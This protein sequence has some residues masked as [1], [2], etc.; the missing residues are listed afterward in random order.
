MAQRKVKIVGKLSFV[1]D[2]S[3][4]VGRNNRSSTVVY[5]GL[6]EDKIPVA[7]KRIWKSEVAA[8]EA[9]QLRQH[10]RHENIA[11]YYVTESDDIFQ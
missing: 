2:E 10:D 3:A 9:E 8:I 1:L 11:R 7:I 5:R 6:F 4:V